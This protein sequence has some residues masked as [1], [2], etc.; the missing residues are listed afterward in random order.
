MKVLQSKEI[1]KNKRIIGPLSETRYFKK[2]RGDTK[3]FP[4]KREKLLPKTSSTATDIEVA[5]KVTD[6]LNS[7]ARLGTHP[8]RTDMV[9][10]TATPIALEVPVTPPSKLDLP[11]S[12]PHSIRSPSKSGSVPMGHSNSGVNLLSASQETALIRCIK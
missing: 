8:A 4:L 1:L 11:A 12:P 7:V 5:R 9:S 6:I 2:L 3:K 10:P